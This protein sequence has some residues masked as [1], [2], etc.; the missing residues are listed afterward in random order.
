M[1][2]KKNLVKLMLM[3]IVTAGTMMS[4]TACSSDDEVMNGVQTPSM[5]ISRQTADGNRTVL[6]YLA[7]KNDLSDDLQLNLKQMMDGSKRIGDNTLLVFVRR[8]VEG[9]AEK[10][11]LA[12]IHDGELK[13]SV[14]IDDMG[15]KAS[16]MHACNPELMEQ[17]LKYAFNRYPSQEYGLVLGGHST[18]WLIGE[19]PSTTRAFGVDQG[20]GYAYSSTGKR[21]INVPTMARVLESVPHLKFIFADCCNFMCLETM[22][23]LR[24]VTDY[25]IGSPAE[26]PD[27]GAPYEEILPALFEQTTFHTSIIDMYHKAQ[28]GYLP[29]SVVKTS[30][31]DQLANATRNALDII[32][33]KIGDGYADT[34]GLIHYNYS[35]TNLD[36]HHEYNLFYDAGDFFRS[37]LSEADYRQWKQALDEA[38]VEKRFAKQWRTYMLW[39]YI[40]S[41]FEMTEEKF[42]GVSMYIPQESNNKLGIYYAQNNEDIKQL[43]WYQAVGW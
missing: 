18:G 5:P 33:E 25:I 8:N 26:I 41:D 15:V 23:E 20:D 34:Q 10:P 3:S 27:E 43:Q 21:W 16:S 37:Q 42:H 4:F 9:V 1:T 24:H 11:W 12:R 7:G 28:N 32:Q 2:T 36:F 35:T 29:L 22:Y 6:V 31:V 14:S 38:V 39:R 19:E 40:Y 30:A 17:V 13:D